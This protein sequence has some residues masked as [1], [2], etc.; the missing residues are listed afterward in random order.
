MNKIKTK[1]WLDKNPSKD[2]ILTSR[3][4][5]YEFKSKT[6]Y[7]ITKAIIEGSAKRKESTIDHNEINTL[8]IFQ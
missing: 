2:N 8:L 3:E 4:V 5:I 6:K 7:I 1:G